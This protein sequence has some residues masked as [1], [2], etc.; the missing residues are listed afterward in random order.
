MAITPHLAAAR[1]A[2]SHTSLFEYEAKPIDAVPDTQH[3][4]IT[5]RWNDK[6]GLSSTK[7]RRFQ[8]FFN[9]VICLAIYIVIKQYLCPLISKDQTRKKATDAE[10]SIY[11]DDG[12][13]IFLL[14]YPVGIVAK[15]SL[16]LIPQRPAPRSDGTEFG[17]V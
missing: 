17:T 8:V 5:F 13:C 7:L 6:Q 16:L 15:V 10:T 1:A 2:K 11:Q 12:G 4:Q 14:P 3:V 9:Y